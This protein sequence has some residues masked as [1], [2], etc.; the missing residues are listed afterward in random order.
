L[1]THGGD[2]L[3]GHSLEDGRELWR[4]GGLNSAENYNPYLRFVA[5]PATLPGLIV[6]PS[7]KSGPV[8]GLR[9]EQLEGDCTE[10]VAARWWRLERGTPDVAT[11]VIDAERGLIYL[12]RENGVLLV[13]NSRTGEELSSERRFADKHRST[14]VLVNGHL[15]ITSRDG[16]IVVATAAPVPEIVT[17][18]SLGEETTA[19]PAISQGQMFVRT[20]DAL[21]AFRLQ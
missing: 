9:P 17:T 1:L 14:P 8:L 12:C 2:Y 7:A 11:P 15:V 10:K 16:D 6:A 5:S 4:V 19:S 3:I 20:Y 21:H 18:V 13:L